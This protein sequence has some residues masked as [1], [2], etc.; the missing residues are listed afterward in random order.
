MPLIDLGEQKDIAS[1][2]LEIFR[3]Q[4]RSMLHKLEAGVSRE[5]TGEHL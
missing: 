4:N 5:G 1:Q 2:P 3:E